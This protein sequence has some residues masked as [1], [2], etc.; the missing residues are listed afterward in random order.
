MIRFFFTDLMQTAVDRME[1]DE[2]RRRLTATVRA[3]PDFIWPFVWGQLEGSFGDG[4][5]N[6]NAA[7]CS[8]FESSRGFLQCAL[9]YLECNYSGD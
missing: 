7:A 8:S 3:K 2:Q 4:G 5:S 1:E 9:L 6:P